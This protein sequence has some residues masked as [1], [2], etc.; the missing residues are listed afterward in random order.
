[1]LNV[2]KF[3]IENGIFFHFCAPVKMVLIMFYLF[4]KN[5]IFK[6]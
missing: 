2:P 5:A 3:R 6:T 4:H 1:M